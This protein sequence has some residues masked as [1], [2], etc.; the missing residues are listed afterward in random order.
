[1]K[2]KNNTKRNLSLMVLGVAFVPLFFSSNGI[3]NN[4]TNY[5]N[6]SVREGEIDSISLGESKSFDVYNYLD[7]LTFTAEYYFSD[8]Q[9]SDGSITYTL[10]YSITNQINT[11]ETKF[12][13][14]NIYEIQSDGSKIKNSTLSETTSFS[15]AYEETFTSTVTFTLDEEVDVAFSTAVEYNQ[16]P[17]ESG[18]V[19]LFSKDRPVVENSTGNGDVIN[20]EYEISYD[21]SGD[22]DLIDDIKFYN[23]TTLLTEGVDFEILTREEVY[24]LPTSIKLLNLNPNTIYNEVNM[25]IY[26]HTNFPNDNRIDKYTFESFGTMPTDVNSLF[27]VTTQNVTTN[28]VEFYAESNL[29]G[30]NTLTLKKIE[31]L[32]KDSVV[33]S[34][35]IENSNADKGG[36]LPLTGLQSNKTYD[37]DVRVT[38]STYSGAEYEV[39]YDVA[40]FTT[41]YEAITIPTFSATNIT[42]NSATL[43][44]SIIDNS[45]TLD[46]IVITNVDTSEVVYEGIDKS[47]TGFE[48]NNLDSN[49]TYNYQMVVS[50]SD[51]NG[52]VLTD[53]TKDLTFKTEIEQPLLATDQSSFEV[54]DTN[55]IKLWWSFED[56]NSLISK[57][58][59]ID[60]DSATPVYTDEIALDGFDNSEL[61]LSDLNSNTTYNYSFVYYWSYVNSTGETVE[62]SSSNDFTFTTYANQPTIDNFSVTERGESNLRLS[63]NIT[64]I[65]STITHAEI[66]DQDNNVV[67]PVS[68]LN[69][70]YN[71]SG[72]ESG[73]TY[74]YKLNIDWAAKNTSQTVE[75]IYSSIT[76]D[77]VWNIPTIND[78]TV[79]E[80]DENLTIS[81]DIGTNNNDLEI[82]SIIVVINGEEREVEVNTNGSI[83]IPKDEFELGDNSIKIIVNY[84]DKSNPDEIKS[85]EKEINYNLSTINGTSKGFPWLILGVAL[86]ILI[87]LLI[88]IFIVIKIIGS[89][90]KKAKA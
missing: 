54:I 86:A 8:R 67:C 66:V 11:T 65:D 23:G 59:I 19:Y 40:P 17:Y 80:D 60:K 14:L 57:V 69:G 9:T 78:V 83:T 56:V 43:D 6:S 62:E 37:Y 16:S 26:Y 53:V 4:I 90:N 35:E 27:S 3:A 68:E 20:N 2:F 73:N 13:Y 72:L 31:I 42:Q 25:Q 71:V 46:N 50:A 15:L 36:A 49:T 75:P 74:N 10:D 28:S 63:W 34:F 61:I 58:E 45:S 38:Y 24:N 88:I 52:N 22:V 76:E 5:S 41:L 87:V 33:Q 7:E 30:I 29:S 39:N 79:E 84:A 47:M 51:I 85:I 89:K 55:S 18:L 21:Y 81:W 48:L 44:W 12:L 1:M 82:K 64:D 70:E 77:T 32:D